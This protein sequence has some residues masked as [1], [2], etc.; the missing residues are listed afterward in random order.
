MIIRK[1]KYKKILKENE[2]L[3]KQLVEEIT[4]QQKTTSYYNSLK[5]DDL[6]ERLKEYKYVILVDEQGE[7][8]LFN[9]GRWERQV[10]AIEFDV[11]LG[12]IPTI[13]ITK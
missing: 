1:K 11:A 10:M 9:Q 5:E 8:K 12:E 3:K 2:S 6:R 4:R 13:Q 7:V